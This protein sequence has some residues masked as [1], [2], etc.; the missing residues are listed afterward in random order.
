MARV[1]INFH[2]PLLLAPGQHQV[3]LRFPSGDTLV[4]DVEISPEG[5][6]SVATRRE[7]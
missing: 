4:L 2:A 1:N 6:V 5:R 3:V 7:G